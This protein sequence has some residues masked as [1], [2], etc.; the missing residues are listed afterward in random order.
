MSVPKTLVSTLVVVAALMPCS[1]DEPAVAQ[2]QA[3][4]NRRRA[5]KLDRGHA[6]NA[7]PTPELRSMP[8]IS[9]LLGELEALGE[10]IFAVRQPGKNGH[11]YVNFG[12]WCGNP[13]KWEYGRGGRLCRLDVKTGRAGILLDDPPGA[14]RDPQVHYDGQKILFSYRPG[15][16]HRFHLH[17][18]NVDGTGLRQL[19]SGDFDD[20][21]PTYLPGGQIMFCSTRCNRVINCNLVQTAVLFVCDAD[22]AN[23]R[24]VS[25]NNE[26]ENTPWPLPDGRILFTRWEYIDRGIGPFKALWTIAPDGSG[27]MTYFGNMNPGHYIDAKPI[28]GMEKIVLIQSTHM[29]REHVGKLAVLDPKRGPDHKPSVKMILKGKDFRDPYPVGES[30]FLV[31]REGQ[32]LAV[33]YPGRARVIYELPASDRADGLWCHEPRLLRSREREQA[34]PPRTDLAQECG[35]LLLAN[36]YQGRNL[37]GVKRGDIKQLLVLEVLPKPVNFSGIADPVGF[38]YTF[39]LFRLL[40]T[41]PVE[42]DGSAWMEL[43]AMR[44][45][46][47]VA[48]DENGLAVKRMQSF[49]TV[50]PGEVTG[51]VGCHEQRTQPPA[52]SFQ[53]SWALRKAPRQIEP[54][55]GVPQVLDFPRD[56]QPILDRHCVACHD[57]QATDQG[58]PRAGGL[59]LAGDHG[60]TFSHSFAVLHMRDLVTLDRKGHGNMPPR[61]LGSAASPLMGYL[62]GSHYNARLEEHER[63]LIRLWLDV[64]APYA[65]T[66]AAS[67]TGDFKHSNYGPRHSPTSPANSKWPPRLAVQS[68][69]QHRCAPCHQGDKR[70]PTDPRDEIGQKA[71]TIVPDSFPRRMSHH[72]VFNLSQPENS[73]LLLAPLSRQNGGYGICRSTSSGQAVF[74]NRSDSDYLVLLDMIQKCKSLL[75]GNPRFD[76]P[77]FR[78]S[79]KYVRALKQ[80]GV[81]SPSADGTSR[82]DAY[83]MDGAYW[84]SF[85]WTPRVKSPSPQ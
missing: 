31:A 47:F 50:Q 38:D 45:L 10:I 20:I 80:Y 48:L 41:V 54:I 36:V 15:K 13:N 81:L 18:I 60:P 1:M 43:P 64:S 25:S 22:G 66:Y 26:T 3:P 29:G 76:T 78:P 83:E 59:I 65:G 84:R 51:C 27:L 82:M 2:D 17:E 71:Y 56:I 30:G 14:I 37:V 11:Y 12:N 73:M 5:A 23:I 57:Y 53:G 68:V 85:W 69:F 19:T 8:D 46:S 67:G 21:E 34:L 6:G 61:S 52:T 9:P 58:G 72:V 63:R 40:G 16:T 62:D 74:E 33:D 70:L 28:P 42:E 4:R 49:V 75:D 32:L 7:M 44:S 39:T 79:A 24:Q 77:G 35:Q 55:L